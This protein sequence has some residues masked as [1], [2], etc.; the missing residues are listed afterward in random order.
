MGSAY[1]VAGGLIRQRRW[2]VERYLSAVKANNPDVVFML[3][4]DSTDGTREYLD[5]RVDIL[6][7]DTGE[8]GYTRDGSDG[9]RYN[10]AHMGR[11]RNLW[12]E[13]ALKRWPQ[14]THLFVCDSDVLPEPD[15]LNRLLALHAPV[16]AAYVPIGDGVTPTHMIG[17]DYTNFRPCRTGE[18]KTLT[19]PHAVTM[20][21]SCYLIEAQWLRF[22][23]NPIWSEHPQGEDGGHANFWRRKGLPMMV[24]PMAK[25][26]HLMKRD[27]R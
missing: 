9:P 4:G 13:E 22:E 27:D 3:E 2:I 14:A 26:L 10:S 18:E 19:K 8:P 6:V 21:G 5:G 12:A 1:V 7:H 15:V 24:D 23:I 11:E 16:A 25:C 20:V 17:F